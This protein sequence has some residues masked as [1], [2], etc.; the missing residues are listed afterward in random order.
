VIAECSS[1]PSAKPEEK[2]EQDNGDPVN[3]EWRQASEQVNPSNSQNVRDIE[4]S[5]F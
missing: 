2:K 3:E 4:R 1:N 5:S